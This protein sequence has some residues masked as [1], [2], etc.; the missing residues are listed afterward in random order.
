MNNAAIV[1]GGS[2][3]IGASTA[4][5]LAQAGFE[6]C[7]NYT[8]NAQ[9]ADAIVKTIRADGGEAIAVQA[10]VSNP[11][12]VTKLFQAVDEA[13]GT[14]RVLV[15]NA[16]ISSPRSRVEDLPLD[17]LRRIMD[18]N[19]I[20]LIHCSQLAI[21]RMST[22]HGGA[23][24]SII[25]ISSGSAYI[26]NPNDGVHYAVSKGAVNS[27]TIGLAQEVGSEGIRV[28][29]VSPGLTNTDMPA[30]EKMAE[31]GPKLPMG[32]VGEPDEIAQAVV[33]LAS[34]QASYVAGANIR[35]SGGRP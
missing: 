21:R 18:I 17:A 28:N 29:A 4:I 25:N 7:V 31:L 35:V 8:A 27:F 33:W 5:M 34:E 13:F 14:L 15:N 1:T 10:D 2:R 11:D 19:V 23:G 22:K 26:G 9:A 32:R 12:D 3:G 20:G 24:G 6:V 16:G 30:P